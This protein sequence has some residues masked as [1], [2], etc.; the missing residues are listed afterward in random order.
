MRA[1]GEVSERMRWLNG[2]TDAMD[3]RCEQTLGDNEGQE[4]LACC[5][6][7]EHT[8][9]DMSEQQCSDPHGSILRN[10]HRM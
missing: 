3:L 8:E 6:S 10:G 4:S 5:S 1:R 9:L 7:W 2:I